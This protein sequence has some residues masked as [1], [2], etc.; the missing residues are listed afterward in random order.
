M[1]DYEQLEERARQIALELMEIK[2]WGVIR[3]GD[4]YMAWGTE[5]NMEIIGPYVAEICDADVELGR[6]DGGS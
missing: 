1:K 5:D 3:V 6:D 2:S 4:C